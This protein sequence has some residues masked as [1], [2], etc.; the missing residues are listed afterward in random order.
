MLPAP[1]SSYNYQYTFSNHETISDKGT[2]FTMTM[3]VPTTTAKP[4]RVVTIKSMNA[5]DL[6][7]IKKTDAFLYYS[8][9]AIRS[10]EVL[11]QGT[12]TSDEVQQGWRTIRS[13]SPSTRLQTAQ[14]NKSESSLTVTRST[15]ISFE[16]H[17][18][19][20]LED[21]MSDCFDDDSDDAED[22]LDTFLTSCS[23]DHLSDAKQ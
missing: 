20:L 1:L 23:N 7:S 22:P 6:E 9:P 11:M 18:D 10:A 14:D 17:P 3:K 15:C 21:M 16:C 12:E 2:D 19:L 13:S 8:I 5:D 4:E